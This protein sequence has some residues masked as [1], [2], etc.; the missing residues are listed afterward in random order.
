MLGNENYKMI[1][2]IRSNNK[3]ELLQLC[4]LIATRFRHLPHNKSIAVSLGKMS[5]ESVRKVVK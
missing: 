1:F 5:P 4:L 2:H 3:A